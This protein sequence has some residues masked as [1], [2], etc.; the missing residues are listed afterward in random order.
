MSITGDTT[1]PIGETPIPANP[2]KAGGYDI[3]HPYHLNH[4]DSPGMT[5]VNTVFDGKG[6][7]GWKRSI[8]LSLSAKKKLG[9]INGACKTPV[10]D[11]TDFEQW[12]CVNDMVTSWILNALSKDIADSVIYSKTAKELWDSLE[13]RFGKSNGAKHFHM[14][15]ELSGLTQGNADIAGYFTKLK[16]LWDELDAL[17]VIITC[18]CVCSCDGKAKLTKSLEDQRLIQFLMGLNDVYAQARGNI[19]MMSPLPRMDIAYSLL[20]QDENQIEIY[21]NAHFSS[22]SASFMVAGQGKKPNAQ[23][24]ADFAAFMAAG[25]GRNIQKFRNQSPKGPIGHTQEDCFRLIGFPDDFEFT[26]TKVYHNNVKANVAVTHEEDSGTGQNNEGNNSNFGGHHFSKEQIAEMMEIYKQAKSIQGGGSG[27]NANAVAGTILKYSGSAFTSLKT[28]SWIID[29]GASE[30]MC[31]DPNSFLF[32]IPLPVP[33]NINLPNSFKD[34]SMRSPQVFGEVREGLYILEPSSFKFSNNVISV[35]EARNSSSRSVLNSESIHVNV[36]PDVKL[37]HERLGHVPFSAMKH[38]H[39]FHC[40]SNFDFICDI[41][42]KAK[43]T[44]IPFPISNIKTKHVFDLIHVDTWGPYKSSTYNGFKYF[45]TIVDDYSRGTWT[46]LS[47]AKSNA[48]PMLKCFLS[49]VERQFN[50]KVKMIRSDNALELGKGSLEADFLASEGIIH[51]LSCVATPQQNGIVERKH[52]HLLEVARGLMFQSSLPI[53][54]WGESILTATHII[55]RL[56]SKV[57]NGKTP[58]EVLFKQKPKYDHLRNFGCL[59]YASTLK[60]GRSKFDQRATACVLIGYPLNQ[61]GY[62]LLELETKKIFVSRDVKFFESHFPFAKLKPIHNPIF[63]DSPLSLDPTQQTQDRISTGEVME[64][65][66]PSFPSSPY[67]H[68]HSP[69]PSTPSFTPSSSQ[70]DSPVP[71]TSPNIYPIQPPN[72]API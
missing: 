54:C 2:P 58:F 30:H 33:L 67:F 37:W 36:I 11:S 65:N 69:G 56:P 63:S 13:Q 51:Q 12:S 8:L 59:C 71:H 44:R 60:Q 64:D 18:S 61:K 24:F 39:F 55:N 45:L 25:Q 9:F 28:D 32:L 66:Y 34:L 57:L 4:S 47:S 42:P 22:D 43:Q 14:Q 3:N 1:T 41:C 48:F 46:F 15:K 31:F 38:L 5:L 16:R 7:P 21:A 50:V 29:S 68:S 52:R 19:L 35:S 40:G 70:S 49:M 20:L 53:S 27:I 10:L 26:N 62:K 23:V 6:Y 72:P 17:N